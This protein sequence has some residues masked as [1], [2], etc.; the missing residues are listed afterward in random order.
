MACEQSL[1]NIYLQLGRPNEAMSRLSDA[2]PLSEE[3]GDAGALSIVLGDLAQVYQQQGEPEKGLASLRRA[4]AALLS[5]P[6][7]AKKYF[8][9]LA[10]IYEVRGTTPFVMRRFEEGSHAA[11]A[12]PEIGEAGPWNA[13][14]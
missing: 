5:A 12:Q 2:L 3:L 13:K 1:G 14:Q 11:T 8:A 6:G 9:K 4:E 7:G 10:N